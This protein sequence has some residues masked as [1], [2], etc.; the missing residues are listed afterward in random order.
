MMTKVLNVAEPPA[1]VLTLVV[2]L[3]KAPVFRATV[4]GTLLEE[5]LF[6]N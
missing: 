1:P 3:A 2:P 4:T 5:I 6:P